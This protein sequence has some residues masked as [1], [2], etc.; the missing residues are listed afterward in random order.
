MKT[1][2]LGLAGL[3]SL[4]VTAF[5]FI[6]GCAQPTS[7]TVTNPWREPL[8]AGQVTTTVKG[9]ILDGMG[10]P[11]EGVSIGYGDGNN[12]SIN[13]VSSSTRTIQNAI[14]NNMGIFEMQYLSQTASTS[15][16]LGGTVWVTLKK[17]G[18]TGRRIQVTIPTLIVVSAQTVNVLDSTGAIKQLVIG[19]NQKTTVEKHIDSTNSGTSTVSETVIENTVNG[20]HVATD[21]GATTIFKLAAE[22]TGTILLKNLDSDAQSSARIPAVGS[23]VALTLPGSDFSPY[24]FTAKT[25]ATGKFVFGALGKGADGLPNPLPIFGGNSSTTSSETMWGSTTNGSFIASPTFSIQEAGGPTDTVGSAFYTINSATSANAS[26][27]L[28]LSF[29]NSDGLSPQSLGTLYGIA[30]HKVRLMSWNPGSTATNSL[31]YFDPLTATATPTPLTFTFSKAMNITNLKPTFASSSNYLYNLQPPTV[32]LSTDELTVTV[33]PGVAFKKN[34]VITVSLT[35]LIAKDGTNFDQSVLSATNNKFYTMKGIVPVTANWLDAWGKKVLDF[36]VASDLVVTFNI[37]PASFDSARTGVFDG[38]IRVPAVISIVGSTLVFNPDFSLDP[39]KTYTIKFAVKSAILGDNEQTEGD[40]NTLI[41]AASNQVAPVSVSTLKVTA[42]SWVDAF[43]KPVA[44]TAITADVVITFSPAPVTF[45]SAKTYLALSTAPTVAL[46]AAVSIVGSTLVINPDYSLDPTKTYVVKFAAKTGNIADV[47]YTETTFT[48]IFGATSNQFT[49]VAVSSL[50]VISASWVDALGVAKTTLTGGEDMVVTFS[51][52]PVSFDTTKTFIKTG[53]VN[54]AGTEIASSITLVGAD[55][56]INPSA[57]LAA[58]TY[59]LE[60]N[61]SS[62]IVGDLPATQAGYTNNSFTTTAVGTIK[63]LSTNTMFDSATVVTNFDP[64]ANL[65]LVFDSPIQDKLKDGT[66]AYT[67]ELTENIGGKVVPSVVTLSVDRKTVTIDPVLSLDYA[68]AYKVTYNVYNGVKTSANSGSLAITP[69]TTGKGGVAGIPTLAKDDQRKTTASNRSV[70]NF[71]D[72]FF[73]ISVTKAANAAS[74]TFESRVTALG[75]PSPVTWNSATSTL[76][77]QDT[78]KAYYTVTAPTWKSGDTVEVRAYS[79]A[80]AGYDNSAFSTALSFTDQV[81][82]TTVTATGLIAT[83]LVNAG[84]QFMD[85][86]LNTPATTNATLSPKALTSYTLTLDSSMALPTIASGSPAPSGV[87]Y[88]V[89]L[90]PAGTTATVN[91]Y[92]NAG[93]AQA[94]TLVTAGSFIDGAQY[95]IVTVGTTDFT[96]IG[97]VSNTIGT[98]F[99][100][101]GVGTGT[102]TANLRDVASS[103]VVN[104]STYYI[105]T[106][107]GGIYTGLGATSNAVGTT[108][109]YTGTTGTLAA[110]NTVRRTVEQEDTKTVVAGDFYIVYFVGT[111]TNWGTLGSTGILNNTFVATTSGTV[112]GT[113]LVRRAATQPSTAIVATSVAINVTYAINTLGTTTFTNL[114]TPANA[115]TLGT[116]FLANGTTGTGTGTAS[117][118]ADVSAASLVIGSTYRIAFPGNTVDFTGAGA[119]NNLEG[120]VF[121]ATGVATGTGRAILINTP[122][123]YTPT[124]STL[125]TALVVGTQYIITQMGT[126]TSANWVSAGAPLNAT[127]GTRFTASAAAVGTGWADKT[128]VKA[129]DPQ[130]NILITVSDLS[131]N[132]VDFDTTTTGVD[133]LTIVF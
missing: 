114:S 11:M 52:A 125:A 60:W 20:F 19:V 65:T 55:L 43:G 127:V 14:S 101:T 85:Y 118:I 66:T 105:V 67:M 112:N 123:V 74:Y 104:G 28:N 116:I 13:L 86:N 32:T 110:G 2:K 128:A 58:G 99:T 49:P 18:Y 16:A 42:A 75:I 119:A 5:L 91:V 70:Y 81:A 45:D 100:A 26:L 46:P 41:G 39:N 115:N 6:V 40:F 68:T 102:G 120:T 89:S 82:P 109:I 62:G 36:G 106:S 71:N 121:V 4:A 83:S 54:G 22:V 37:A 23:I 47:E 90:N 124:N 107:T 73:Y 69:F 38:A 108:F 63:L 27:L 97:A 3:I 126:T 57:D 61:V 64:T 24:V 17:D 84:P 30:D 133:A 53:L 56:T 94:P 12:P 21:L 93:T 25:D 98:I 15:G 87:T 48:N 122:T 50:R 9:V 80:L 132:V 7:P 103:R 130:G 77:Y 33:V 78:T 8:W 29:V 59:H 88:D 44:T 79:V 113:G 131:G 117:P 51:A 76:V 95:T 96:L 31:N 92:V 35:G 72:G 129:V 34:D 10:N 111:A 1:S